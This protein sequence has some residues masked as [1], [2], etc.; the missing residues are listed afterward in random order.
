MAQVG[1]LKEWINSVTDIPPERQRLMGW[2]KGAKLDDLS[3]LADAKLGGRRLML[4]GTPRSQVARSLS[5]LPLPAARS[6]RRGSDLR[7]D[8][9]ARSH[10]QI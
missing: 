3:L 9:T 4:M 2:A 7:S 6:E 5:R 10:C 8:L 1:D